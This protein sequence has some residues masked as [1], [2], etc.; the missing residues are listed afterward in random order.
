MAL[1]Q[2]PK[3]RSLFPYTNRALGLTT[4]RTDPAERMDW[5]RLTLLTLANLKAG[6]CLHF[7]KSSV[8]IQS[9]DAEHIHYCITPHGGTDIVERIGVEQLVECNLYQALKMVLPTLSPSYT[10]PLCAFVER[11]PSVFRLHT[12]NGW[13]SNDDLCMTTGNIQPYRVS[14]AEQSEQ[15]TPLESKTVKNEI[16]PLVTTPPEEVHPEQGSFGF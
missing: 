10:D 16:A 5:G 1:Y 8:T 6:D 12:Q 13:V 9:I 11:D 7:A 3:H 14:A 4:S 2:N 15:V